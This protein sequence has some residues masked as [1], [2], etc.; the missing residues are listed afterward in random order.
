MKTWDIVII[1]AGVIGL[2]LARSLRRQG[3]SVLI[4][5][6][7]EPGREASYAAGGMI[8]NCDAHNRP[9][10]AGMIAASARMYSEFVRELLDESGVSPDL[11]EQGTI[12][13]Y[14]EVDLPPCM[15]AR[16]LDDTTLSEIEP[17]LAARGRC[18]WLPEASVD[19]RALVSALVKAAKHRGVDFVTGSP[20]ADLMVEDGRAAGVRTAKSCYPSAV[21]V[22]CAG[23]WASQIQPLGVPTRPVKGQIVC[24]VPQ[25]DSHPAGTSITHVVRTNSVYLIPR[26]DGRI[27]LG[28]T[29]EEAGYDKRVDADTVQRL[30]QAATSAVPRIGEMRILEAWAGLRPGSPDDLPILGETALPGYFAATGHYRDGIMLAPVTAHAMTQLLLG[31]P[32]DFDL[33]PFSPLRFY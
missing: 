33:T 3:M 8:A 28:A 11:R 9:E 32:G 16:D 26:S 2:A 12:A 24:V 15:E 19:P 17:S 4:V 5:E 14:D 30:Y 27:L 6:R 29:V 20:V 31:R 25:P 1:G 22:N 10:L 21:V 18:Y 7:G 23:A 13:F